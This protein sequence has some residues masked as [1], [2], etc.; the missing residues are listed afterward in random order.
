MEVDV[1]LNG[2]D[3]V[4]EVEVKFVMDVQDAACMIDDVQLLQDEERSE[5][6]VNDSLKLDADDKLSGDDLVDK[7][8]H[9]VECIDVLAAD[10]NEVAKRG[11]VVVDVGLNSIVKD[12]VVSL[13]DDI[14]LLIDIDVVE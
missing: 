12:V 6:V 1:V 5:L 2:V 14:E 3:E 4:L 10:V 7:V 13:N 8:V 9:N 11:V